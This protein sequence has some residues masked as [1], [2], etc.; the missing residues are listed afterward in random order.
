MTWNT[1]EN[2]TAAGN[3][4]NRICYPLADDLELVDRKLSD[5]GPDELRAVVAVATDFCAADHLLQAI[6]IVVKAAEVKLASHVAKTATEWEI[7][8][9]KNESGSWFVDV[10]SDGLSIFHQ[11]YADRDGAMTAGRALESLLSMQGR[12]EFMFQVD[13]QAPGAGWEVP[14]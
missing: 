13:R 12:C 2:L 7:N 4:L 5:M 10:S 3:T 14:F 1:K 11:T 6:E 8:V 9:F